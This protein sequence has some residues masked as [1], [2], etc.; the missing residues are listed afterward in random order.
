MA[1]PELKK[2]IEN[3]MNTGSFKLGMRDAI[4]A[5]RQGNAKL[6]VVAANA[7]E[8]RKEDIV[9]YAGFS[10]IPLILYDGSS[11]ELGEE[12]C[13]RL[14]FVA[15]IAFSDLGYSNLEKHVEQSEEETE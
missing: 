12:V 8:E 10:G 4:R 7:P 2:D 1:D 6:I 9:R 3:A 11:K 14:H 15:A 5:A 13:G